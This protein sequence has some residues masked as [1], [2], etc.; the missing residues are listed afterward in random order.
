MQPQK[1]PFWALVDAEGNAMSM[2]QARRTSPCKRYPDASSSHFQLS[3]SC[4]RRLEYLLE[5]DAHEWLLKM[6][7]LGSH[8]G[9]LQRLQNTSTATRVTRYSKR[10]ETHLY[11][12]IMRTSSESNIHVTESAPPAASAPLSSLWSSLI[13]WV[14]RRHWSQEVGHTNAIWIVPRGDRMRQNATENRQLKDHERKGQK[15]IPEN[16]PGHFG[17]VKKDRK[18]EWLFKSFQLCHEAFENASVQSHSPKRVWF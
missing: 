6:T 9:R 17:W 12:S 1:W 2:S 10:N 15:T 18:E 13:V 14:F 8:A 3:L 11:P 5:M 7:W 16:K 4:Q